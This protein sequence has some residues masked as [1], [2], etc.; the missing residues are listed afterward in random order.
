M[1]RQAFAPI[2][3][4]ENRRFAAAGSD[5]SRAFEFTRLLDRIQQSLAR[6]LARIA[7]PDWP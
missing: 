1:Q 2:G 6:D 4:A 7:S 5:V 3:R